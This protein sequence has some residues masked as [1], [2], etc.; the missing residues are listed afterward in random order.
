MKKKLNL[1]IILTILINIYLF[2]C[3]NYSKT[4]FNEYELHKLSSTLKMPERK[5]FEPIEIEEKEKTSNLIYLGNF[6]LT[7][8]CNCE[9]CNGIWAWG[10][11]YSGVMPMSWHTIAVD[12]NVIPI[13]THVIING[14]EYVAE[15]TGSAIIGNRIDIYCD[16]HYDCY[17]DYCNG[18][19]DVY[20]IKGV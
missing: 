2:G 18:Y 11:T 8:Y 12:T 15:D 5:L 13:G 6:K 7:G 14:N 9:E 17:N 10:P 16:N 3:I 4:R 1:I 20:I 19:A